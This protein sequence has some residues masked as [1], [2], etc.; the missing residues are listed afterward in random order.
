M[1]AS[2]DDMSFAEATELAR[3]IAEERSDLVV[4]CVGRFLTPVEM[5]T[6]PERWAVLVL[7]PDDRYRH[8]WTTMA[9]AMIAGD[10]PKRATKKKSRPKPKTV[11]A[12]R[13]GRDLQEALF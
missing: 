3:R 13:R 6:K 8:F 9:F 11:A 4:C 2:S 1:S 7:M 10:A 12:E 5:R